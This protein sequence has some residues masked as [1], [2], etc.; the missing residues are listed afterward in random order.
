MNPGI[1]AALIAAAGI[2]ATLG[3]N[4][5][6][7]ATKVIM[8]VVDDLTVDPEPVKQEELVYI[9]LGNGE[10]TAGY[11]S[12]EKFFTRQVDGGNVCVIKCFQFSDFILLD[13]VVELISAI[14]S[15]S[16]NEVIEIGNLRNKW[17]NH[18]IINEGTLVPIMINESSLRLLANNMTARTPLSENERT[19]TFNWNTK[20]ANAGFA[21]DFDMVCHGNYLVVVGAVEANV[22][23]IIASGILHSVQK[24]IQMAYLC[25]YIS[26]I[27]RDNVISG[28]T[29]RTYNNIADERDFMV[30]LILRFIEIDRFD[31][32]YVNSSPFLYSLGSLANIDQSPK[33][34]IAAGVILD[35]L[36]EQFS[37]DIV[38][39]HLDTLNFILYSIEGISVGFTGRVWLYEDVGTCYSSYIADVMSF[40]YIMRD[41]FA[42]IQ[43]GIFYY[44]DKS[45]A[46][47][48]EMGFTQISYPSGNQF[49]STTSFLKWFRSQENIETNSDDRWFRYHMRIKRTQDVVAVTKLSGCDL[50]TVLEDPDFA[51]NGR[52]KP[53]SDE[54]NL[55]LVDE[56]TFKNTYLN[57]NRNV[58]THQRR[59]VSY[60]T[61]YDASYVSTVT[62]YPAKLE[63]TSEDLDSW[64]LGRRQLE[65]Q[66]GYGFGNRRQDI[67][68]NPDAIMKAENCHVFFLADY[69]NYAVVPKIHM[70]LI[71]FSGKGSKFKFGVAPA[72]GSLM[73]A[74]FKHD[75]SMDWRLDSDRSIGG[76]P[77]ASRHSKGIFDIISRRL[78]SNHP[79]SGTSCQSFGLTDQQI[80]TARDAG[81][82]QGR[83]DPSDLFTSMNR[84][85]DFTNLSKPKIVDSRSIITSDGLMI[86]DSKLEIKQ[87]IFR[88]KSQGSWST[89]SSG[90]R[91]GYLPDNLHRPHPKNSIYNKFEWIQCYQDVMSELVTPSK[92]P[93]RVFAKFRVALGE[94]HN[95]NTV[96]PNVVQSIPGTDSRIIYYSSDAVHSEDTW[97]LYY[98]NP[99]T[100]RYGIDIYISNKFDMYGRFTPTGPMWNIGSCSMMLP[101]DA[102]GDEAQVATYFKQMLA[103]KREFSTYDEV[104][105]VNRWDVSE[106]KKNALPILETMPHWNKV[107]TNWFNL[108]YS[109]NKDNSPVNYLVSNP[110]KMDYTILQL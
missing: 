55:H 71:F 99:R 36:I 51:Q 74:T 108:E 2:L 107:D 8:G 105:K 94:D 10:F 54:S 102:Y 109:K 25:S 69:S 6:K 83:M 38:R 61:D 93:F 84:S 4:P 103:N 110:L 26:M 16:G 30:Q 22:L 75:D 76:V 52:L 47:D 104:N 90:L 66:F 98:P 59:L 86:R 48:R 81:N 67:T 100:L 96:T 79:H 18:S 42:S 41:L 89:E 60:K 7:I 97:K 44:K 95:F 53:Y 82:L 19:A 40:K 11:E 5:K 80:L 88:N 43:N 45:F 87:V 70:N 3:L 92:L 15:Y 68:I 35:S 46:R 50:M 39:F 85:M 64:D 33:D 9:T 56:V 72:E 31:E 29:L 12:I 17:E 28:A 106:M 27:N 77:F 24:M 65:P 20:S 21:D 14:T 63:A 23:S 58:K 101:F 1:K 32:I 57:D 49:L 13:N 37:L 34:K 62:S 91:L 73:Y 78:G